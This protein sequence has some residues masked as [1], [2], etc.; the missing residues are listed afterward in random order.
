[1]V[2]RLNT[3]D[4]SIDIAG[5]KHQVD[6][7][8]KQDEALQ[9][10]EPVAGQG[11]ATASING[12][13]PNMTITGLTGMSSDSSCR[14]LTISGASNPANNGTFQITSYNNPTSIVIN[15]PLGVSGDANNGSIGWIER[16]QWS[17]QDDHNFHR[18]DRADIKGVG[19]DQ[20]VPTYVRCTD[21]S[22]EINANLLNISGKTTDAKALVDNLRF[23]YGV[24]TPGDVFVLLSSPGNL[25]HADSVD[26]TGVPIND[27]YDVGNDEATFVGIFEGDGYGSELTVLSDQV[28]GAEQGWRVYGRTRAG[29]SST[30]PNSV[31]IEFRAVPLGFDLSYSMPYT[32]EF[33]QPSVVNFIIGYRTCLSNLSDV[34]LRKLLLYGILYGGGSSGGSGNLPS[35][36]EY[37]EFLF[38]ATDTQFIPA[39]PVVNDEGLIMVDENGKVVVVGV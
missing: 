2:S 26:I 25:K 11:G 27:G 35:P 31:E 13:A 6:D 30:S 36:T 32:W 39:V 14:F 18:T 23:Q 37:G 4:Q 29:V 38:A 34:A 28:G 24:M 19:Y 10:G 21:Q 7:L 5:T 3:L 9:L 1:M 15:N 17:A 16:E 12:I 20:P 22:L 33:G 8:D